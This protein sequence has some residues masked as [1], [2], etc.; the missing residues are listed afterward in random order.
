MGNIGTWLLHDP[1]S[2]SN[3]TIARIN[4]IH[5]YVSKLS[6]TRLKMLSRFSEK[7]WCVALKFSCERIS[8]FIIKSM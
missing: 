2:L 5:R 3:N 7:S 8:A 1:V 4:T 6:K